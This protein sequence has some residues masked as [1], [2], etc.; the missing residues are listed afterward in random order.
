MLPPRH[1][2][3]TQRFRAGP[4]LSI[5]SQ[6]SLDYLIRRGTALP[7][8]RA[9]RSSDGSSAPAPAPHK[10]HKA[11]AILDAACTSRIPEWTHTA[12]NG[13][14]SPDLLTVHCQGEDTTA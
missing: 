7:L 14:A 12:R 2:P 11:T 13:S 6:L 3:I 4:R 5:H 1:N 8:V 10:T 9:H